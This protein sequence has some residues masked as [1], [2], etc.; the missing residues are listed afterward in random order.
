MAAEKLAS[1]FAARAFALTLSGIAAV[2]PTQGFADDASPTTVA[3][4]CGSMNAE[5]CEL[6]RMS[7][8]AREYAQDNQSVAVLFH[9][10]DDVLTRDDG[11]VLM[12]RVQAHFEQQFADLGIEAAIFPSRNPGTAATGLTFHYGHL[13]FQGPEGRINLDL[14]EGMAAIPQVAAQLDILRQTA[15]ARVGGPTPIS[16]GG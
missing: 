14:Q 16:E 9:I 3:Y 12:G 7:T 11:E 5:I 1:S 15:E 13:V 4:D 6:S 2:A 10:G 8:A